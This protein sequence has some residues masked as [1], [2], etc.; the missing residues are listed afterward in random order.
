MLLLLSGF[1]QAATKAPAKFQPKLEA[2]PF[3]LALLKSA[4][5]ELDAA[6]RRP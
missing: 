3:I 4:V 2:Q 1:V 6:L 5:Q